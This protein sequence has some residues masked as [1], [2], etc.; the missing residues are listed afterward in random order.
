P[1]SNISNALK[2]LLSYIILELKDNS[3]HL[4][5]KSYLALGQINEAVETNGLKK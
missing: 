1:G 5:I 3:Y 4:L 2:N